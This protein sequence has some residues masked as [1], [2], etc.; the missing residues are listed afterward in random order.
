MKIQMKRNPKRKKKEKEERKNNNM[1]MNQN[2][3]KISNNKWVNPNQRDLLV[4]KIQINNLE[5]QKF[6]L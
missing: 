4:H 1:K 5:I 6:H 2:N 3:L